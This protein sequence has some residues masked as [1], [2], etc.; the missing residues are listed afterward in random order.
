MHVRTNVA[1]QTAIYDEAAF[2]IRNCGG[3]CVSPSDVHRKK[4]GIRRTDGG[5]PT[6]VGVY[7]DTDTFSQYIRY[8]AGTSSAKTIYD[9]QNLHVARKRKENSQ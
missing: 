7:G 4:A 3:H 8:S 2:E 1:H 6:E 9:F 5:M